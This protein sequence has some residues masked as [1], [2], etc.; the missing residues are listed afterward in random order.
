MSRL[1][2]IRDQYQGYVAAREAVEKTA[3]GAVEVVYKEGD[4]EMQDKAVLEGF[5]IYSPSRNKITIHPTRR[6]AAYIEIDVD[7]IPALVKALREFIE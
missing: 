6:A 2:K 7:D 3:P 5:F 1:T 4:P